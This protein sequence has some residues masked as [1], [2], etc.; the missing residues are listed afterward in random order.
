MNPLIKKIIG[1]SLTVGL[2]A[3]QLSAQ[4]SLDFGSQPLRFEANQGQGD[5]TAS[6]LA[7]GPESEF[8]ISATGAQFVLRKTSGQ[9]V[10]A[11]MQIVG[12]NPSA[13]IS[14]HTEL[15]GKINYLLGNNPAQWH[16]G[17]PT[18]AQVR[19]ENVYPGVNVVYYGN[20]RQLE[21]DFDLAAG[22][23]PQTIALRFDDAEKISV[24]PQGELVVSLNGGDIIQHPP[25]VYQNAGAT[26]REINGGYKILDPHTAT[27]A[28][29]SYDHNLP[30][31][32]DPILG[33]STYFGGNKGDTA[34]AIAVD[35][36]GCAYI[37]GGT[38]STTFTNISTGA[39]QAS[40]QGGTVAGDAFVAKF[41]KT[42]SNLVY[43]TYLGGNNEDVASG[44][45]VDKSGNAYVTGMTC[46]TN[47][48]TDKPLYGQI[49]SKYVFSKNGSF[50]E[51]DAF[52]SELNTN[53][54]ELVYST[55]LGGSDYNI[56]NAIAVDSG[57]NAYIVG[58]TTSSDFP[59]TNALQNKL[60]CTNSLANCNAF[61][62]EISTNGTKLLYSSYLGGNN[63]DDATSITLDTSNFIYVAGFTASTNFPKTNILYPNA[64]SGFKYLNG[65][66]NA[67][68]TAAYDA[69]V[70]KFAPNF[71]NWVYST[72]LGGTNNDEA[73]GIAADSNGN[74][75]VVGWTV[76]TNFPGVYTNDP[77]SCAGFV[78][79]YM[80]NDL[81]NALATTN[82]FL[83]EISSD[84]SN[85]LHT[86]V[87]GGLQMDVGNGV[88]LDGAGNIFVVGTASSTNFPVTTNNLLGSLLATNSG[89]SDVFVTAFKA[90]WSALLYSTYLGGYANDFGN[91]IAVDNAGNAYITGYTFSTNYPSF[92][93]FQ[94]A[95]NGTSAGNNTSDAFLTK[96]LPATPTPVLTASA[97]GTNVWVS[98]P[99]LGQESPAYLGLETT[100]N[101]L[102][103][104]VWTVVTN[105]P[106]TNSTGYTYKLNPTNRAQFFR[107]Y[108]R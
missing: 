106:V 30:L 54:T 5:A 3:V 73:T 98:W 96:I 22:V 14:G 31:V 90:D 28:L 46:S 42:G 45:A 101:L 100:T 18:F 6:F 65:A 102:T 41:D 47:F 21:Y 33:Y 66:T 44:I 1:A 56:A 68:V 70:C 94:P 79:N 53:G 97:A 9:T 36:N 77:G 72:Y 57:H 76:S 12:A 82:A 61:I 59:M 34:Y 26:R 95:L 89:S 16:T 83:T 24:N 20:G 104:N 71:T 4:T 52:V 38:L 8:L 11:R 23:T 91:A 86:A 84:G 25:V 69:F 85:I 60:Q 29:S 2:A 108:Q 58:W 19:V 10:A 32:I 88:A 87:F 37:A 55:Y 99:P 50:Y 93:A 80:T 43:F 17:V 105:S 39:Y 48:P 78:K 92:N 75:Y 67:N 103:T 51:P 74:A 107:L 40:F 64:L 63:Y 62:T 7:H 81:V 15:P 35:T 49:T 13:S 27:F